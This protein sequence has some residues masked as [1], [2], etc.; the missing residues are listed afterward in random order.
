MSRSKCSRFAR[1]H[2]CHFRFYFNYTFLTYFYDAAQNN[3]NH[4]TEDLHRKTFI[5][6]KICV[7]ILADT[8]ADY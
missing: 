3:H 1:L 7:H 8:W 2:F 6:K 4:S 5:G